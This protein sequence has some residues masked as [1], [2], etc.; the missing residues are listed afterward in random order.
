MGGGVVFVLFWCVYVQIPE[1]TSVKKVRIFGFFSSFFP[2]S[3]EVFYLFNFLS[4]SVLANVLL[5]LNISTM[6]SEQE[7]LFSACLLWMKSKC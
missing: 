7:S 3:V 5:K 1:L 2:L 6:C 4:S